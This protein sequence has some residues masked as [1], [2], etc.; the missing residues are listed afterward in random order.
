MR[1]VLYSRNS[2]HL[3]RISEDIGHDG[4]V[5]CSSIERLKA[6]LPKIND[7]IFIDFRDYL[8]STVNNALSSIHSIVALYDRSIQSIPALLSYQHTIYLPYD[9]DDEE[10]GKALEKAEKTANEIGTIKDT[11]VGDSPVMEALRN[12]INLIIK[13]RTRIFHISGE[14]G[15]GKNLVAKLIHG[16]LFSKNKKSVYESC[17]ALDSELAE[18]RFFGHA[19]GAYTG[20]TEEVNGIISSANGGT[21][22][23]DEI[24]DLSL[25][26]QSKL[27]HCVETGEYRSIGD[28]K[29]KK[30][31]FLFITASNVN[32]ETLV[33]T[34]RM[35]MDFF[36]RIAG[37]TIRMPSL[38]EHME[39]I[40][41][42][43][44]LE[45]EKLG[46]SVTER[47]T[48][49]TPFMNR[50]WK[51]NVRELFNAVERYHLGISIN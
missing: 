4:F 6:M 37:V 15:T 20:A 27:L 43:I 39:D 49:F 46:K 47:I 44:E 50:Q 1:F 18:S 2:Q 36:H 22:F 5:P 8:P 35:R 31:S 34:K 9:Y 42:L 13:A 41:R 32:L 3:S 40:P 38:S 10:L 33:E 30:S 12:T 17:S 48:D 51:G 25:N 45:E 19:K 11:L 21:L 23:L 16:N 28:D 14:T 29:M 26:M 7:I 24:E